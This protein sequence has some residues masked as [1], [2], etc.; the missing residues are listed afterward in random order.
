[1][2]FKS[3]VDW[4]NAAIGDCRGSLIN[5]GLGVNYW[6]FENFGVGPNYNILDLDLR[7]KKPDW[8]GQVNTSYK[9]FFTY[10]SASC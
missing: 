8:Q 5:A 2:V 6:L 4:L 1:M 3:R 9:G 10:I 7:V